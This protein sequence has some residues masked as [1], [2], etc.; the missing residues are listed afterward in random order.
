LRK[1]YQ[2]PN[3]A[4]GFLDTLEINGRNTS[5][6]GCVQTVEFGDAPESNAAQLLEDFVCRE[7]LNRA[8]WKY[9]DGWPGGFGIEQS[10]YRTQAGEYGQFAAD[11]R[12]RCVD[13]RE[14]G[15]SYA[16]S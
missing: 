4:E 11:Q 5:V 1:T 9:P 7:F 14:L 15:K 2:V 3:R 12:A 16:W 10:L 13:W 8:N 6:M